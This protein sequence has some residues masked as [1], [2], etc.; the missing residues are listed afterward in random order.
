MSYYPKITINLPDNRNEFYLE[1]ILDLSE[2]DPS[3]KIYKFPYKALGHVQFEYEIEPLDHDKIYITYS[4]SK[5]VS[6]ENYGDS[7]KFGTDDG[8]YYKIKNIVPKT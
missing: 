6:R 1:T 5:I 8:L 7:Y 3:R 4:K 2:Y